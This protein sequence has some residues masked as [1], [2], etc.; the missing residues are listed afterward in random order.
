MGGISVSGTDGL[1]IH[2]QSQGDTQGTLNCKNT[3][4]GCAT[5]GGES[6]DVNGAITIDGGNITSEAYYNG[7][8]IGGAES[9]SDGTSGKITINGGTINATGSGHGAGI[10]GG[11]YAG[12]ITVT[13]SG[14]KI[15]ATG[16]L[17]GAGIG[18]GSYGKGNATV[19]ITGGEINAIGEGDGAGIGSGY[20][21]NLN[22]L[23]IVTI[24]GG[25]IN[26]TGNYG[27]GIGSGKDTRGEVTISGGEINA[28]GNYGAGI[29]GGDGATAFGSG[30]TITGGVIKAA[31]NRGSGIGPGNCTSFV[32]ITEPTL[33]I[34]NSPFIF[35]SSSDGIKKGIYKQD[36]SDSWTNII[37]MDGADGRVYG[38]V[39]T[40]VD[41]E[42]AKG[43]T[44][45]VP[46]GTTLTVGEGKAIANN[47]TIKVAGV[48]DSASVDKVT[49]NKPKYKLTTNGKL[50]DVKEEEATGTE[51][52]YYAA[53]GDK[54]VVK[55][56]PETYEN[57]G[58]IGWTV[59][60]KTVPAQRTSPLAFT[61]PA[62]VVTV[63]A[64]YGDKA[65]TLDLSGKIK[66]STDSIV[67]SGIEE[68]ET[69]GDL[70]FLTDISG[71]SW[72][73]QSKGRF[74]GLTPGT[75]YTLHVR[76]A[77]KDKYAASDAV[78]VTVKTKKWA[79]ITEAKVTGLTAAY[80][81]NLNAVVLPSGW[82]W[83]DSSAKLN[84]L[85]TEEYEA[86]F[87]PS[88]TDEVD[89]SKVKGYVLENDK[90]Y[91]DTKLT[92]T[93]VR[94]EP[95]IR[96]AQNKAVFTYTGLAVKEQELPILSV[97]LQNNETY[98]GTFTYSYREKKD[99]GE[100]GDFISGLPKE[101]GVYEVKAAVPAYGN[102]TAA[103]SD[104]MILT[105]QYLENTPNAVMI[106][107]FGTEY[108]EWCPAEFYIK[109]PAAYTISEKADGTYGDSFI[110]HAVS[111]AE[112]QEITYYLK[113]TDGKI[114]QKTLT[115][116]IDQTAPD[117]NGDNAGI[118]I[119]KHWWNSLLEEYISSI[120]K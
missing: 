15:N 85:G 61:M 12:D 70:E 53:Y 76:Y 58:L 47:G 78:K 39:T 98:G 107:Q 35:A 118:N 116:K 23:G 102:Y 37:S 31:S 2:A 81:Q 49:V 18:G 100:T 56:D 91:L 29:G 99:S 24:S 50:D 40:A 21:S 42:I 94:A 22:I 41:F 71:G 92:V 36:D 72:E 32:S 101:P 113:N 1:F 114:A 86:R 68:T 77:G 11:G 106:D 52:I 30:I 55:A 60:G 20:L 57:K 63:T 19:T 34:K 80:G 74:T 112:Q 48:M 108:S 66:V 115:A 109:A 69:Y 10:G 75:E 26:A 25:K 4:G 9:A 82:K 96:W 95:V 105:I 38:N 97:T 51:K 45:S 5:I 73:S 16:G 83:K 7:A 88:D 62:N 3:G 17:L 117:W 13:I 84:F 111:K 65:P 59:S 33:T 104:V 110:Y 28:T 87:A 89:Y 54:T 119:K 44:L 93:V 79:D 46:E 27:A 6:G 67:I 90:V 120:Y 64:E 8:G 14:G 43:Q 103:E